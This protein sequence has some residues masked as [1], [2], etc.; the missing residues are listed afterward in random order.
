MKKR[1]P[2]FK[3]TMVILLLGMLGISFVLYKAWMSEQMIFQEMVPLGNIEYNEAF[4]EEVK[5]IPGIRYVSG[6]KEIPVSL[7]IGDYTADV[8]V[9][10]LDFS[11]F[12]I[13]TE[14]TGTVT[15]GSMPVF[16]LGKDSLKDFSDHNGH[17]LSEKEQEKLLLQYENLD[18]VYLCS[19]DGNATQSEAAIARW[20]PCKIGAVLE[21]PSDGIYLSAEQET[22]LAD[23]TESAPVSKVLL[24]VKGENNCKKALGYFSG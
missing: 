23:K 6:V 21:F 10:I 13:G 24:K 15:F 4:L 18:V 20:R 5:K 9:D 14:S 7:R 8:T 22:S 1:N 16:L 2:V 3:F 19:Y 12:S 11:C 17:F